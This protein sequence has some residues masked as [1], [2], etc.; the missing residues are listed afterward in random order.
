MIGGYLRRTMEQQ[1]PKS[2]RKRGRQQRRTNITRQKL[3]DAAKTVF[4]ERGLDLTR[5]DEITERADVGKGTFYY[6]FRSKEKLIK[7]LIKGMLGELVAVIDEK[8]EGI[9]DLTAL[10][11]TLIQVHTEFF[12]N[13]WEDFVLFFQGRADLTLQVSYSGIDTPFVDYIE[14]MESLLDSVIE[15]RI[16]KP[17]LRRIACAVAGFLSGYYSFAVISPQ[18]EDIDETFRSLRGAMVASLVRFIKETAPSAEAI[19]N[20]ENNTSVN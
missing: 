4:S 19:G 13:R 8:C 17:A 12:S 5:I 15:H 1:T 7:E 2:K 16:S 14:R 11:D 18:G 3:L 20:V 6:H 9:N 10:M